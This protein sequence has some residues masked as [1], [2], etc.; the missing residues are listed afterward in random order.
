MY[1]NHWAISDYRKL[2]LL[3][4][5]SNKPKRSAFKCPTLHI[6]NVIATRSRII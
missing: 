3:N 2:V 5:D 4:K 6:P 1:I